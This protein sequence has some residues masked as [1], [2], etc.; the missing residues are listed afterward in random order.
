MPLILP[1]V[2]MCFEGLIQER[3]QQHINDPE[4]TLFNVGVDAGK[5]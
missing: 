4:V 2:K 1:I 5:G 3:P